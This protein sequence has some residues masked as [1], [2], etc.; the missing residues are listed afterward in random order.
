MVVLQSWN[1]RP[2]WYYLSF[3]HHHEI[4]C[5]W[6]PWWPPQLPLCLWSR[7]LEHARFKAGGMLTLKSMKVYH[8]PSW[9]ANLCQRFESETMLNRRA[10]NSRCKKQTDADR[11]RSE[12]LLRLGFTVSQHPTALEGPKTVHSSPRAH[13][14]PITSRLPK[15]TLPKGTLSNAGEVKNVGFRWNLVARFGLTTWYI[16]GLIL[17]SLYVYVFESQK[18]YVA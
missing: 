8:E 1:S 17:M 5:S 2:S 4:V 15:G 11:C 9:Y 10:L 16:L 13:H 12:V 18:D 3:C 6:L 14:K 7:T